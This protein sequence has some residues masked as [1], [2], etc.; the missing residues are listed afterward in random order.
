MESGKNLNPFNLKKYR[1]NQKEWGFIDVIKTL[2]ETIFGLNVGT[3]EWV[4]NVNY[5]N[6]DDSIM[7]KNVE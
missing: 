6:V 5:Q 7:A 2:N 4:Q 3:G 1:V